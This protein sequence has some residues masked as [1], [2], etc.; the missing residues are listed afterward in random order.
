M[1]HIKKQTEA[2]FT[3]MNKLSGQNQSIEKIVE[4]VDELASQSNLLSVNATIEASKAGEHGKGFIVV[5]QEMKRLTEKSQLATKEVRAILRDI[6]KAIETAATATVEGGKVIDEGVRQTEIAGNSIQAL[7]ASAEEAAEASTQI[8]ISTQ[9]QLLGVKQMA[10]AMD[11]IKEA[12]DKNMSS[13]KLLEVSGKNLNI[14]GDQLK[15]MV[16]SYKV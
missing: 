8:E 10:V 12:I 5:A 3:S 1:D 14:L 2:I 15:K 13:S 11:N 16:D 4:T 7:A 9:Q 6:Q